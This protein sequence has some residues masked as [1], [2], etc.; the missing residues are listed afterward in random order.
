MKLSEILANPIK[1][2][3]G[4][5]LDLK[6]LSK[7]IVDKEVGGGDEFPYEYQVIPGFSVT[8]NPED[9][10][11]EDGSYYVAVEKSIPIIHPHYGMCIF[12]NYDY[13]GNI[14]PLHTISRDDIVDDGDLRFT[15][16]TNDYQ[17]LE[18]HGETYVGKPKVIFNF[19]NI[20][21]IG[22]KK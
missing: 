16:N 20:I 15:F 21:I 12:G 5:N 19:D 11:E 7:V 14:N 17:I 8:V 10:V 6:D 13:D 22:A 18:I 1:L 4:G 9:W 3:G 2:K